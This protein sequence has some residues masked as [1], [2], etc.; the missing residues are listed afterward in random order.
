M[1]LS[2]DVEEVESEL[3]RMQHSLIPK[4]LHIFGHRYTEY[5][6]ASYAYGV[7]QLRS[8]G[9]EPD[10]EILVQAQKDTA[11]ATQNHEL[12]GLME[13]LCD[14]FSPP[15]LAG[16]LFRSPEVFPTGYNLYQ[17]DARQ[18]PS[19]AALRRGWEIAENTLRTY[20]SAHG[21]YPQSVALIAW[22]L[23]ASRTQGETVGQ[24]LGY[25]GVRPQAKSSLWDH[26]YELIPL[27]EL[28]RP[29]I[30]V[31][32]NICGFFRDMFPNVMDTLDD[33]FRMVYAANEGPVE[34]YFRAHTLSRQNRL[35]EEGHSPEDAEELAAA[36]L[37]GPPEGEYGTGITGIIETKNWKDESELGANFT[38]SLHYIYTRHSIGRKE[39]A[40]YQDNL[41]V[42]DVISQLRASTE[43]EITD[44][45]HYYEFFGGL[46]KSV[47][48]VKGQKSAMYITDVTAGQLHT[49]TVDKS[50]ARGLRTRVLNP[51]WIDGLL[52]HPYHGAQK[53]AERFENVMGLTATTGAVDQHFYDDLE[54]CYVQDEERRRQMEENNPH[55][56]LN[57]LEQML[58]YNSRGYWDASDEQLERIKRAYLDL[59]DRIED[60]Q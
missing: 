59:E 56:Y 7:A 1:G 3:Y 17:F 10:E 30:D 4:G 54:A 57:I 53:I 13:A 52:Q 5:E 41:S 51:T 28:G 18:V 36:R 21:V 31:T 42:V 6:M 34:N 45:D 39:K 8:S 55:A 24:I 47:E 25:L 26:K 29:R 43:Y 38:D 22:G 23:E 50:I 2:E 27:S 20:Q 48:M 15:R 58:E 35:I 14:H 32:V 33:I 11:C 16:D 12:D 40:L 60:M 46:A 37:F 49:E 9:Q 44:L 19:A